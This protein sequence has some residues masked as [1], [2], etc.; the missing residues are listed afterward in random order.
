MQRPQGQVWA[1]HCDLTGGFRSWIVFAAALQSEWKL[2]LGRFDRWNNGSSTSVAVYDPKGTDGAVAKDL[3]GNLTIPAC[4]LTDFKIYTL[5][6]VLPNNYYFLG[7]EGKYV[8]LAP[9]RFTSF[10]ANHATVQLTIAGAPGEKLTLLFAREQCREC[11]LVLNR[12]SC[13]VGSNGVVDFDLVAGGCL[14]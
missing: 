11:E 9:S 8:R 4:N 5:S 2:S 12:Y 6:G 3:N 10:F 7:E 13:T 1:T 14:V